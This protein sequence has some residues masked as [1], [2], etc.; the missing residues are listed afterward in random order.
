MM[1]AAGVDRILAIFGM[2]QR[3]FLITERLEQ[4]ANLNGSSRM[5][6]FHGTN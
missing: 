2:L 1:T 4:W 6:G 3:S 5:N